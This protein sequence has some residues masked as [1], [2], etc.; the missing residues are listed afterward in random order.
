MA[1]EFGNKTIVYAANLLAHME[2]DDGIRMFLYGHGLDGEYGAAPGGSKRFKL[3]HM[4]KA[5][6]DSAD[7]DPKRRMGAALSEFL[8]RAYQRLCRFPGEQILGG[9]PSAQGFLAVLRAEG[10]EVVGDSLVPYPATS[11][12]LSAEK[13]KLERRLEQLGFDVALG[14]LS[15]A[16]DSMAGGNWAAANGQTRTFLEAVFDGIAARKWT[17]SGA[18][19]TGGEA[20]RYLESESVGLM[21][22]QLDGPLVKALFKTLHTEGSHPGLSGAEDSQNRLLMAVAIAGR[23]L[24]RL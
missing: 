18:P 10:W 13:G 23:Y 5:I 8:P 16:V 2:T 12:S 7:E 14:H 9:P 20:R 1:P 11:I 4:L 21:D 3:F 15:Q 19:P 17:G 22:A 6:R 24:A